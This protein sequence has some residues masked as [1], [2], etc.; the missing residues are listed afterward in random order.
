[1]R[2]H[3]YRT[4]PARLKMGIPET[5]S[6]MMLGTDF[7]T[8]DDARVV[9]IT[10][11]KGKGRIAIHF[12]SESGEALI[13]KR[14]DPKSDAPPPDAEVLPHGV[15]VTFVVHSA[16]EIAQA[17]RADDPG[18][19]ARFYTP[20]WAKGA[21]DAV[22]ADA[23]AAPGAPL[24]IDECPG[25]NIVRMTKDDSAFMFLRSWNR[26]YAIRIHLSLEDK[27]LLH[28]RLNDLVFSMDPE[29][30]DANVE[31]LDVP[32]IVG[33]QPEARS[34]AVEPLKAP[35]TAWIATPAAPAAPAEQPKLLDRI[36]TR[37]FG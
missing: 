35:E 28:T 30:W 3:Y 8:I 15:L 9:S 2:E 24:D 33:P 16:Q 22:G 13:H 18:D 27:A 6:H 29:E 5:P 19:P 1:M 11:L 31:K 23:L 7:I 14:V 32:C 12:V 10:H 26:P 20:E 21:P 37:L 36:I 4:Q 34:P 25:F 17:L